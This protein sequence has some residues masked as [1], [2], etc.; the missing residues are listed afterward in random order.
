MRVVGIAGSPRREGNSTTLLETALEVAREQGHTT[1]SFVARRMKVQPCIACEGCKRGPKCVV[2]DDMHDIY[3][4]MARADTLVVATPIYYYAA[5]G[6]LKAVVDRTY[7]L[8][9]RESRPR[10]APGKK[11]YVI[12]AQEESDRADGAVVVRQLE[13]AFAWLGMEP[14]G[15]IIATGLDE[16]GAVLERPDLLQAARE[17][18]TNGPSG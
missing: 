17:L 7:G 16:A 1:K 9:D 15:S 12:T 11:L 3:A 10:I 13:R 6:W 5:S 8:L 18:I 2:D 14:A 4:A